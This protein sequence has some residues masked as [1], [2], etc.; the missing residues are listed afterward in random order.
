[1]RHEKTRRIKSTKRIIERRK[2]L[3]WKLDAPNPNRE[4]ADNK[5]I[6]AVVYGMSSTI[7]RPTHIPHS[8]RDETQLTMISLVKATPVTVSQRNE[9]SRVSEYQQRQKVAG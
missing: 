2:Q 3:E 4:N 8:M 6:R 1:M 5:I 9:M 7:P